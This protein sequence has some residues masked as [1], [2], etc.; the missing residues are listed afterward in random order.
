M[1]MRFTALC[2]AMALLSSPGAS[3]W[4]LNMDEARMLAKCMWGEC[5]GVESTMERAA[6]AWTILN[7]VDDVRF[8]DTIPDVIGQP[9]QFTGYSWSNPVDD[10]L[11]DLAMDVI[12]RWYRERDGE[13][14]VGRILPREYVY[15]VGRNGRN[16]FG[17]EW[18]ISRTWDWSLEDPYVADYVGEQEHDNDEF[19]E[20]QQFVDEYRRFDD[21]VVRD[22][23]ADWHHAR[24]GS[25]YRYG[26]RRNH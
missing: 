9:N 26:S 23:A 20:S 12:V 3:C 13:D 8:P 19:S 10:E 11:L 17:D 16:Y 25:G 6:V 7:R 21:G 5:R 1:R 24:R 2:V 4:D 14:A 15:F 22:S 18:P